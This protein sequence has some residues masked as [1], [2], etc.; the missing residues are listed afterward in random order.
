MTEPKQLR[1]NLA[2]AEKDES[3]RADVHRLGE[4]VGN[5]IRE[6]GGETLFGAVES[7]RLAA[8]QQ[9]ESGGDDQALKKVLAQIPSTLYGD[10]IRA[11]T[12]WFQVVNTA[13]QIHRIRR[14]RAYLRAQESPQSG[15]L[16]D[17]LGELGEKGVGFDQFRE[18][19]GQLL[20]EPVFTAH[21]TEPTRR[22]IL[23]KEQ[24]IGRMLLARLDPT[25]TPREDQDIFDEIQSEITSA[26]Q[27]DEHPAERTTVSDE[28]EHVLFYLTDVLYPIVPDFYSALREALSEAYGE[29]GQNAPIPTILGIG[30]QVGGDM[31]GNPEVTA[32]TIKQTLAR[33]RSLILNLYFEECRTLSSKLSQSLNRVP[34]DPALQERLA[35]YKEWYPNAM[36]EINRRHRDM[37]YRV[38]FRLIQERLQD[39]YDDR[40]KRYRRAEEFLNDLRLVSHSLEH[41]KGNKAGLTSVNRLLRRA[42]TFRFKLATLDIRLDANVFRHAVGQGLEEPDWMELPPE[43]RI[44]RLHHVFDEDWDPSNEMDTEARKAMALFE[45]LAMC[46]RRFGHSSV[47]PLIV[48]MVDGCDD[49]LSVLLLARWGGLSDRAG[50]VPL[51]VIPVFESMQDFEHAGK[52]MSPLLRDRIYRGHLKSRNN[53]QTVMLG[54]SDSNQESGLVACRWA[55]QHAHEAVAKIINDENLGLTLFLGRGGTSSRSGSGMLPALQAAPSGGVRG[56]LR[57]IEQGETINSKYGLPG[58]ALRNLERAVGA[59]ALSSALPREDWPEHNNW[60]PVMD[61]LSQVSEQT[62]R[63]LVHDDPGFEQYFRT[64]TPIDVIELMQ[65]GSR[66]NVR[67]QGSGISRLRAIPFFFAWTQARFFLPYWYGVGT[68]LDSA[69]EKFGLDTL[70]QLYDQWP[71]FQAMIDDVEMGLSKSDL[72]MARHYD[73][74][75]GDSTPQYFEIIQGEYSRSVESLLAVKEQDALLDSNPSLQRSIRLRNPYVDPINLLQVDLL[76]QWRQGGRESDALKEALMASVNGIA[77]ALQNTG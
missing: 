10:M 18:L 20:F 2:F 66:G 52:I 30:S 37:P 53:Q 39:T 60:A 31:E 42:E 34:I 76:R 45:A 9:R 13:E 62:Y 32:K 38:M 6:Q 43:V 63:S 19:L 64:V 33:H 15:S 44:A 7:A 3:L 46:R 75:G 68:A 58:I 70:R 1:K 23:R 73:G 51:D 36:H 5:M 4:M 49:L 55:A 21:P 57:A 40:D 61:H 77:E 11:F 8:I 65:L 26:W 54:Y 47:G 59:L 27:T 56:R 22:T 28:Q 69:I 74:L 50:N 14:R 41:H 12:A 67:G 71:F 72:A 17:V 25:R 48:S 29:E 16:K 24:R 35:L